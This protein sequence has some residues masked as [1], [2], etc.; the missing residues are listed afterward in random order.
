MI[1]IIVELNDHLHDNDIE[2]HNFSLS[3]GTE[4]FIIELNDL[5]SG[6]CILCFHS[7]ET[8]FDE[9]IQIEYEDEDINYYQA[10][11]YQIVR[12]LSD[13]VDLVEVN[14]VLKKM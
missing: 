4:G 1:D 14:N 10:I 5:E 3:M 6:E 2:S 9:D 8:Y 7:E 11:T 13:R 12:N